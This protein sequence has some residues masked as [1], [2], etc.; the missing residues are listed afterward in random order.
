[1]AFKIPFLSTG[2]ASFYALPVERMFGWVKRRFQKHVMEYDSAHG[3]V[4]I[5]INT[6]FQLIDLA[7]RS[8][9]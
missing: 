5:P 7:A 8:F 2:V 6:V 1:M 9:C 3:E 4:H